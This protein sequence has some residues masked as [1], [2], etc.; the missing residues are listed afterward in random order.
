MKSCLDHSDCLSASVIS[1]FALIQSILYM[2]ARDN[3][4]EERIVSLLNIFS[5]SP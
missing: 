3:S 4:L 2:V 5:G 1:S